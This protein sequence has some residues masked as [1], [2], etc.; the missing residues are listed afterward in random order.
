[1]KWTYLLI[2]IA[3]L[4]IPFAF[5]FHPKIRFDLVWRAFWPACL[6]TALL[7][8]VWD[9][10]FTKWSVWSFNPDYLLGHHVF[11]L[12]VEEL[13][14]FLAI[15][16]ACVF[17]YHALGKLVLHAP[18]ARSRSVISLL[19]AATAISIAVIHWGNL[20]TMTAFGFLGLLVAGLELARV[21][22]LGRFY[23][24]YLVITIPFFIVNGLLTGT[25]LANAIVQYNDAENLG[26]RVLTIPIED[27]FYG[28]LLILSNVALFEFFKP[29]HSY[30]QAGSV[31]AV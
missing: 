30:R 12:P 14:F 18:L 9:A 20:Y 7:F 15:P 1:M 13:L 27:W 17:T 29:K 2:D 21:Q 26:I 23:I 28:M 19:L 11:G 10:L 3:A 8:I 22:W 31:P 24:T 5:T 4:S 25:G 16:Y 6:I